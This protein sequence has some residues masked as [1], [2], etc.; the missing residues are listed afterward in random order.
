MGGES[1]FPLS[2][3]SQNCNS[4]NIS[5]NCEKQLKKV[6]AITSY[7]C[8]FIFLS[9]L[10]LNNSPAI[11]DIK[12]AFMYNNQGKYDLIHHS[13]KNKR[14][15]GILINKNIVYTELE[16]YCN[17][18]ENILGIKVSI[19]NCHIWLISIYGPNSNNRAFFEN[20]VD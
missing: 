18:D 11:N 8:S 9:D 4:L 2:F 3:A 16:R 20:L 17:N 15:V 14:G 1:P 7:M 19:A 6:T 10:P 13:T 12:S 5:T